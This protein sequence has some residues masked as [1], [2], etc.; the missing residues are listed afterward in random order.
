MTNSRIDR[1][2][3]RYRTE[4]PRISIERAKYYTES[5]I[6]SQGSGIS[7]PVRVALAMKNVYENM[8]HHLDPD[9]RIAGCWT[10][11]F[12]GIPIDIERGVFNRVLE[13]ELTTK[14][15]V[16]HRGRS[17]FGALV[18]LLRKGALGEFVKNQMTARAGGR[19][20]LDMG[21]RTMSQRKINAFQIAGDDLKVLKGKLLPFWKNRTVVDLLE[22]ELI[23]SGLHSENMHDFVT[24]VPGNTSR[25]VLMLSACATIASIQGHVILDYDKVL[26]NGLVQMH[27]DVRA[28]LDKGNRLDAAGKDFLESLEIALE[29]VMVFARRLVEKIEQAERG[30]KDPALRAVLGEMLSCC[31]RV[32]FEP[33]GTFRQAVQSIWTVKTA[34]ELA[35]PVNLHCFGRLDQI[36]HPYYEDD[37]ASGRTDPREALELLEELLLKIMSQNIRPESNFLSNF[38]QRFLGSSPVTVGGLRPDG[39]DG[40]NELTSLFLRAAHESRAI[41]NMSVRVHEKTPQALLTELAEYLSDGTSSFSLFNDE[42]TI[43]AMRRRGFSEPDARDYAVMGCVEATCPGKTGSMSANALLLTRL[44]DMTLRNGDSRFLA[45]TLRREGLQTGAAEE[46]RSFDDLL[47]AFF[48]QG[49]HFIE[50]IVDASNLR[51]RV[52][53]EHLPAPYISAFIDGCLDKGKDV[54]RGGGRYDLTGISMINSIAN[55]VDSL[56]V[57]KKLVFEEK[58]F[59]LA[60][61][62]RAIDANFDGHEHVFRKIKKLPGKWGNGNPD[63]DLLASKVMKKLFSETYRYRS[64]KGGPV[65]V[66]VISMTTHTIDGRLSGASPDGRKAA[67]PFAAS[68]NP[69]NVERSGVTAALRSIASLPFEDVMG[70]AVNMKFHPS[71]IGARPETRSK[72]AALIRTYFQMGGSQLQ[73]TCV[74]AQTLRDA[75]SF[76]ER[77]GDLIV[78]VGGYSTYFADLGREIQQEIIDRT[79]HR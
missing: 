76:P 5:W 31:R 29:G 69:A 62:V 55:L 73:P 77:H 47:S 50:K 17:L 34:V 42:V 9:D 64:F 12:F 70:C 26:K 24:A 51:D 10:E 61:L 44:L 19:S 72:W 74:S 68:C 63:C 1:I 30:E 59:S 15:M 65:V 6:E 40:T 16:Y 53:A 21:L 35:H 58:A 60:E 78:K 54:T 33:A 25:Q 56:Y 8:N 52:M 14:S 23:R 39:H 18:Y 27:N 37:I 67:T 45:G 66:Y 4:T 79:E 3:H 71:A 48:E 38:Y 75:R 22:R 7:T 41:T 43:E 2:R 20:P 32:P 13:S 28:R 36:L 57:I 46:F 11:H 49:A